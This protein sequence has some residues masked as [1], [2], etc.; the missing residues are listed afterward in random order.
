M[1]GVK[2]RTYKPLLA[3]PKCEGLEERIRHFVRRGRIETP[4]GLQP[5]EGDGDQQ[6]PESKRSHHSGDSPG[7]VQQPPKRVCVEVEGHGQPEGQN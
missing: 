1:E 6:P 7:A 5:A 2:P 3:R 4:P